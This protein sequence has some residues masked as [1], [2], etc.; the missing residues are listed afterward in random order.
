[1][2]SSDAVSTEAALKIEQLRKF[3]VDLFRNINYE[4]SSLGS[5]NSKKNI[6]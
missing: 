1:M 2:N 4:S 3:F 5:H 6:E